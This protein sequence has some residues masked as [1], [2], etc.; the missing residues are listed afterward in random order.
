MGISRRSRSA[1]DLFFMTKIKQPGLQSMGCNEGSLPPL[2][3][4]IPLPAAPCPLPHAIYIM[5]PLP[6]ALL[7]AK[8]KYYV[9]KE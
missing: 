4:P 2:P 6:E 9:T 1:C 8:I 5:I 7:L 3:L